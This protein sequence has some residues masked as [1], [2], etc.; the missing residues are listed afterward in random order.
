M[1]CGQPLVDI[2]SNREYQRVKEYLLRL[3]SQSGQVCH[4]R[5]TSSQPL[6]DAVWYPMFS[7]S[8]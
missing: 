4:Y 2:H 5:F 8:Q 1:Q 6:F 3:Y 7:H